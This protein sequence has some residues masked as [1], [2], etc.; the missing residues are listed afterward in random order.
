MTDTYIINAADNDEDVTELV[1]H[2]A[3]KVEGV[4][5]EIKEGGSI[6][7]TGDAKITMTGG[8]IKIG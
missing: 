6:K 3:E 4:T 1:K 5:V 8:A 7:M 2:V